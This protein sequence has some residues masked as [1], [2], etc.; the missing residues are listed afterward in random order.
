MSDKKPDKAKEEASKGAVEVDEKE[1]DQAAGGVLIG[2]NQPTEKS[3]DSFSLNYG[4]IET[5]LAGQKVTPTYDLRAEGPEE[6][7]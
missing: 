4:K 1:L 7:I 5:N 3:V 6:K 2:L